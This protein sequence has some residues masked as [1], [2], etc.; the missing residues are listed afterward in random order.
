MSQIKSEKKVLIN[1]MNKRKIAMVFSA[2]LI[3]ISLASLATKG[4]NLGID[5]TGGYL[6][7]V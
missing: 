6:I 1:F 2:I 3:I 5:F 7:E 4:L